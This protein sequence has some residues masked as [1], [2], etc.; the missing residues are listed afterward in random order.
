VVRPIVAA[1]VVF[2]LMVLSTAMLIVRNLL[3]KDALE[4]ALKEGDEQLRTMVQSVRDAIVTVNSEKRVVLFN[5]AAERMFDASAAKV[6]GRPV[7]ELL[8]DRLPHAQLDTLMNFLGQG[9]H[10]GAVPVVGGMLELTRDGLEIPV[11]LSISMTPYRGQML[12]TAVFRDLSERR[13]AENALFETNRQ[14]QKLSASLQTVREEQRAR[15]ARELHDELGQL[16]TG[17]RMEMSW[18]GGRIP[19]DQPLLSTKVTSIKAQIDQTIASVRRISSEL[20]PLVLDDLGLVA[21]VAWYVDQFATRTGLQVDLTLSD[22]DPEQRGEVATALFRVLQESLTNVVRH[23]GASRV[24]IALEFRES[25]W[26][27]SVKDNG[28]GF[29]PDVGRR[30]G[31]GLVGM[32]ERVQ[33]LGGRFSVSSAPGKG[34]VV[35]V[36]LQVE[37]MTEVS[38]AEI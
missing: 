33:I 16:L 10:S 36:A 13:L 3:R 8:A 30:M 11:E 24:G 15:I 25:E 17:I 12:L 27:L 38:D 23:A 26:V 1:V 4:D 14:L 2:L 35:E 18:L 20:R 5:S 7:D 21:A 32:R 19:H 28:V 9:Q 31:F 22:D 6:I 29:E 37:K 34:T